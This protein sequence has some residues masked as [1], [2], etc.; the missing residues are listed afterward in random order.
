MRLRIALALGRS[1]AGLRVRGDGDL[2]G[3]LCLL[4]SGAMTFCKMFMA[5]VKVADDP[6]QDSHA[7]RSVL[8]T[9]DSSIA[10]QARQLAESDASGRAR[11]KL[12]PVGGNK[13]GGLPAPFLASQDNFNRRSKWKP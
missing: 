9:N 11:R 5:Q 2:K 10:H 4:L 13:E 6:C 12:E 7:G 1:S 8:I 3:R